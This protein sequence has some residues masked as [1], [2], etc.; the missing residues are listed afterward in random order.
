MAAVWNDPLLLAPGSQIILAI[1]DAPDGSLV[2]GTD[3]ALLQ[4]RPGEGLHSL[5][6]SLGSIGILCFYRWSAEEYWMG[7]TSGFLRLR[8]E[9][10]KL[11]FH[12]EQLPGVPR[13]GFIRINSIVR[14]HDNTVWIAGNGIM[15]LDVGPHGEIQTAIRYTDDDGLPSLAIA[16]L[17]ED[18]Q[19]N[20]W[21]ATEGV[22]GFS[23]S[24]SR[25]GFVRGQRRWLGNTRIASILEDSHGRSL[26][27]QTSWDHEPDILVK[28]GD[29][30][31]SIRIQHPK[32]I[33]YFGWGWN[34]F[35]VA[36]RDGS[37]WKQ[38]PGRARCNSRK[39]RTARTC[40]TPLRWFSTS[41]R[42]SV[43]GRFSAPG[44][45]QPAIFGSPA[46]SR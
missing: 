22:G 35:I 7:T 41:I 2:I 4:W 19:G 13:E 8:R 33:H 42:R 32:S 25:A 29:K 10:G 3:F 34:Q 9:G 37:W 45:T 6:E 18:A 21:G 38:P 20:L 26:C 23:H 31:R 39:W 14:R 5:T 12:R 28:D 30:F 24:G 44:K 27:V 17:V 46:Q 36:A 1:A 11:T 40:R 16:G 15:R 43:A